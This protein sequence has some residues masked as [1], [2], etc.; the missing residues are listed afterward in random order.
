MLFTTILFGWAFI[1]KN[2]SKELKLV[3]GKSNRD[4]IEFKSHKSFENPVLVYQY[5][6]EKPVLSNYELLLNLKEKGQNLNY[7]VKIYS[8]IE[9]N[10]IKLDN[11][12]ATYY[13]IGSHNAGTLYIEKNDLIIIELMNSDSLVESVFIE[14][15]RLQKR[16]DDL[17][18]IVSNGDFE[19]L[20]YLFN[21]SSS[22]FR[23]IPY[24]N[25]VFSEE[26]SSFNLGS[27][28][29][30]HQ[31][32][33]DEEYFNELEISGFCAVGINILTFRPNQRAREL[34][35]QRLKK[36]LLK[37]KKYR[38]KM[39]YKRRDN[40]KKYTNSF[41][42]GFSKEI[43]TTNTQLDS[44]PPLYS[45]NVIFPP[46][47]NNL[48]WVCMDTIIQMTDDCNY[49]TIGDFYRKDFRKVNGKYPND[50]GSVYFIVDDISLK[51][52]YD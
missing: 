31:Q 16:E 7:Q 40:I 5:T 43:I 13:C 20:H 38:L 44:F 8:G 25:E 29:V 46:I 35:S 37:D 22:D 34:L 27:P 14:S 26:E 15:I 17:D 28:D 36:R 3:Y 45:K 49:L 41:G 32:I 30:F 19:M 39:K 51:E 10:K 50:K 12:L 33:L 6:G 4:F 48:D 21:S 1:N 24:W 52:F 11:Q 2:D 9:L 23:G 18:E 42:V 47:Q